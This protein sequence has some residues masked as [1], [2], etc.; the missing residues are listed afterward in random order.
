[1]EKSFTSKYEVSFFWNIPFFKNRKFYLWRLVK[2][3]FQIFFSF[4]DINFGFDYCQILKF[5]A[6]S[7]PNIRKSAINL[8]HD[9]LTAMQIRANLID[10]GMDIFNVSKY[11]RVKGP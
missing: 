8:S 11:K 10:V 1:M 3:F 4:F 2:R 7:L 9:D 6:Q 5:M